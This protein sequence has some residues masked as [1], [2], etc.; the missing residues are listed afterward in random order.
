MK[1]SRHPHVRPEVVILF[2][3][4]IGIA[5]LYTLCGC[6]QGG[7]YGVY[8]GLSNITE[9]TELQTDLGVMPTNADEE[10]IDSFKSKKSHK[11]TNVSK[12]TAK[13]TAKSNNWFKNMFNKFIGLFTGKHKSG[14][15][16][17]G[18]QFRNFSFNTTDN[19]VDESIPDFFKG[20]SFS[21]KCCPSSYS[22]GSGCA[23]LNDA[24]YNIIRSRGGNN[25]PISQW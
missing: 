15:D 19:T 11:S 1:H 25:L 8:E 17:M 3:I 6:T 12:S 7:I 21:S 2:L 24:Q 23:C 18:S 22:N 14:F 16:N 4:V 9:A 5:G 13:S 10:D 20:I